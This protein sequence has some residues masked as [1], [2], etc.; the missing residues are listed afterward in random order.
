MPLPLLVSNLINIRSL[1]GVEMTFGMLLFDRKKAIKLFVDNRYTEKAKK[2]ALRGI[3]VLS[4]DD[5]EKILKKLKNVRFEAEDVTVARLNRWKK[6]YKGVRWIPSE[7]VIEEMRRTKDK[8]EIAAV[9]KACRITDDVMKKI[10]SLLRRAITEKNL[11]WEIEKLSRSLGADAMAFDTIVGFGDHTARPHHSPT[12]R[13][14][15]AHDIVQIDMG[16][17][18]NGYCSDC[19]RVFFIGKPTQE[20]QGVFDLLAKTVKETTKQVKAGV[21]NHALDTFARSMLRRG[22]PL[23]RLGEKMMTLTSGKNL[24]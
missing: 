24:D 3:R 1:T 22:A 15:K 23:G 19:S 9:R 13:K 8:V 11:A 6:R 16:V 12:D 5:L 20:Q 10:P 7:G 14:L 17:K 4:I 2:E 18:V 21:T